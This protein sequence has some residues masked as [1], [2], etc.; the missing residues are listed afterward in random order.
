MDD[1][2]FKLIQRGTAKKETTIADPWET[3]PI[4]NRKYARE[5]IEMHLAKRGIQQLKEFENFPNLEILYLNDNKLESIE[6]LDANFRVKN[7]YLF[8]NKL[9]TLEGSLEYLKHLEVLLLYSNELRDLDKNIE[10]LK[11]YPNLKTLDIFDNPL[12]EEPNYRLRVVY[13]LP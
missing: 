13:N 2:F 7:L 4:K 5:C 9:K 10:F 8:N 6:G 3:I 1:T 12:C 11:N